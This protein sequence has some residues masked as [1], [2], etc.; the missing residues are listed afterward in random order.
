MPTW[1]SQ[2]RK[3]KTVYT[4]YAATYYHIMTNMAKYIKLFNLQYNIKCI[5][6]LC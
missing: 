4:F 6:S 2:K 1:H 5:N 3:E